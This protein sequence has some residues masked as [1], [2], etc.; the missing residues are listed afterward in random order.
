MIISTPRVDFNIKIIGDA[1]NSTPLIFLHGFMG[2]LESWDEIITHFDTSI[3]LIDLPGHGKSH[4]KNIDNYSFQDW[5]NDFKSI[6]GQLEI[7]QIN[8]CG[9]SMG[10][11]LFDSW[12]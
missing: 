11:R 9:Y 5:N 8:L 10:G 6:L 1:K 4:F 7:T 12:N 2:S 3:V